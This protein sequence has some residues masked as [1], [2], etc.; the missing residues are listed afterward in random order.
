MYRDQ[1]LVVV[2]GGDSAVEEGTYLT[3][4]ASK[5]YLVHRRNKLRASKAM[6]ERF[7]KLVDQGKMEPIWDSVVTE[8]LGNELITGVRLRNVK[9]R[10]EREL[11]VKGMFLAIGHTPNTQVFRDWLELDGKG[12]IRLPQPG[13]TLT[14]VDGV[15]AA[16]DVA[17]HTYRQAITAA[18]AGCMAALD[19]ERRASSGDSIGDWRLGIE[20]ERSS[21]ATDGQSTRMPCSSSQSLRSPSSVSKTS[22]S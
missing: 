13:R 3:K 15:F 1:D 4:F 12:Y 16:G 21:A 9:T 6:Q 14:S 7:F 5:V 11:A 22:L 19:A 20:C 18:G 8:V 2:G 10:A 17:D